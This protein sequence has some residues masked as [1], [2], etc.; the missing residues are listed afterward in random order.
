MADP[1]FG[2]HAYYQA[3]AREVA[4][5]L[6][7]LDAVMSLY[8]DVWGKL[9]NAEKKKTNIDFF[10]TALDIPI[11]ERFIEKYGSDPKELRTRLEAE[12]TK[13]DILLEY[14]ET[15]VGERPGYTASNLIDIEIEVGAFGVALDHIKHATKKIIMEKAIDTGDVNSVAYNLIKAQIFDAKYHANEVDM[16]ISFVYL[17]RKSEKILSMLVWFI[18]NSHGLSEIQ[19]IEIIEGVKERARVGRGYGFYPSLN[20][21]IEVIESYLRCK[22]LKECGDSNSNYEDYS[23]SNYMGGSRRLTKSR[24]VKRRRVCRTK[25]NRRR[26]KALNSR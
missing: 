10:D 15:P 8:D 6:E 3:K 22:I 25:N 19:I 7:Q 1:A 14:L 17:A 12:A 11:V 26:N 4:G 16:F 21:I 2:E 9:T 20:D 18:G 24:K 13:I 5:L 23:N